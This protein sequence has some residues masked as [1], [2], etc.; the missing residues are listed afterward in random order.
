MGN[1]AGATNAGLAKNSLG[2]A[3]IVF[4]VVAAA[5]P[6]TAVVGSSPAAFALGNGAGV[7]GAFMLAGLLYLVFSVGFTAMSRHV[8]G[9][10][11]FYVFISSGLGSAVGIGGAFLALVTYSAVQIAVYALLGVFARDAMAPFAGD[12]PWYGWSLIGLF[13]VLLCGQRNIAVSGHILGAC[14]IAEIAILLLLDLAI[15]RH[16]GGPQGLTMVSFAPRIVFGPGLGVALVFVLGS[17]IGFESAVIFG[18]EA[19]NPDKTIRRATFV[20]VVLI[21]GFY[22]FSTWAIAQYFGPDHVRAAAAD[23][24]DQLFFIAAQVMLGHWA[25]SLMNGLLIISLLACSLSLHST[26][27]RYLFAL[28]RER[29]LWG[30]LG[31]VHATHGSPQVAGAIQSL[32]AALI[33]AIFALS[34]ADPYRLVFSWMSA[35]AVLGILMVQALVCLAIIAF[36]RRPGGYRPHPVIGQVAPVVSLLGLLGAMVLVIVNLPLLASTDNPL[37]RLFPLVLVLVLGAG[38]AFARRLRASDPRRYEKLGR[39]FGDLA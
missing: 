36:F 4:F 32:T 35:L 1:A 22:A 20:A 28:G 6:L 15:I 34:G 23:H 14:M 21:T 38:M 8:G 18:E 5:A 10:G 3:H 31:H 16:G 19:K 39:A 11:G 26:L 30:R 9:A 12:L 25:V 33:V 2:L 17:Y 37:I 29:L 13:L 24:P 7:P 27:C